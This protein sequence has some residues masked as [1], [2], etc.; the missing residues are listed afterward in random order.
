MKN[1]ALKQLS[2]IEILAEKDKDP[3][4]ISLKESKQSNK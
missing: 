1:E 4:W 3:T 2:Q